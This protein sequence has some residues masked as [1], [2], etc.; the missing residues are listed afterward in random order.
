LLDSG[1]VQQLTRAGEDLATRDE[2]ERYERKLRRRGQFVWGALAIGVVAGGLLGW[3]LMDRVGTRAGFTGLERE[4]NNS[5]GEAT[6]LP[7]GQEVIGELGERLDPNTSDRDFFR[8]E[9]P[10]GV[11]AVRIRT[12]ALPN[13]AI[14]TYLYKLGVE[15]PIGRYCSGRAGRGVTIDALEL[16]PGGYLIG[17]MQDRNDGE[18]PVYENVSDAYRLRVEAAEISPDRELEPNDTPRDA[19]RVA[20]GTT[21][22]GRLNWMR[23]VDAVCVEGAGNVRFVVEDAPT[24]ARP[25]HSVLEV[26]PKGGPAD[27]IP[28]RVHR[29][30]ASPPGKER[31]A[32]S[33]WTSPDADASSGNVCVVLQLVVNP[34]APTPHP[35]VAPAS[36]EEYVVRVEQR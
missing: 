1:Q 5:A 14:C 3:R 20:P 18:I 35:R 17:L 4:P 7:F 27:G 33:P 24:G 28:V 22:R 12:G 23:D 21:F 32:V 13:M 26:T 6:P 19:N 36:D 10:S 34:W 29:R 11:R 30:G 8:V 9:V 15:S 2:V 25:E 31:D 16:A